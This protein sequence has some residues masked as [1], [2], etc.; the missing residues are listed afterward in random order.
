MG[1]QETAQ[2]Q[3][4]ELLSA[5]QVWPAPPD[6]LWRIWLKELD[7]YLPGLL[8]EQA[9]VRTLWEWA[10]Q[11]WQGE[12]SN[13]NLADPAFE[14]YGPFVTLWQAL[15]EPS[16]PEK[17]DAAASAKATETQDALQK[18]S[19][20]KAGDRTQVG[21][22][23]YSQAWLSQWWQDH[24]QELQALPEVLYRALRSWMFPS[25]LPPSDKVRQWVQQLMALLPQPSESRESLKTWLQLHQAVPEEEFKQT[26][27]PELRW[28]EKDVKQL[29]EAKPE[30]K[31]R[32]RTHTPA[33][34]EYYLT[35]GGLVILWPFLRPFFKH[36]GYLTDEGQWQSDALHARAPLLLWYLCS[37]QTE[38][39]E[40]Q[41]ALCKVLAGWPLEDPLPIRLDPTDTEIEQTDALISSALQPSPRLAQSGVASFQANFLMREAVLRAP[42]PTWVLQVERKPF[43]ILLDGL[44]WQWNMVKLPWLDPMVQVSWGPTT[45]NL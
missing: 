27:L 43:D 42:A 28:L 17:K 37:G 30:A 34:E 25:A 12:R 9:E 2:R 44:P 8:I 18:G 24:Q 22:R 32:K 1:L 7:E 15:T 21:E 4:V 19:D 35:N 3:F 38:T 39:T 13:P 5:A 10:R 16:S 45:P 6:E 29:L 33:Q 40:P 31:D 26:L 41:L 20:Q 23:N 11:Q 14:A 36:V